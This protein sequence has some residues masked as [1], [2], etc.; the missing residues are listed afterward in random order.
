MFTVPYGDNVTFIISASD[1][2]HTISYLISS[3]ISVEFYSINPRYDT[4]N[5][6]PY[7]DIK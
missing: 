6:Y 5:K 4:I 1:D 7:I 3:D 2:L